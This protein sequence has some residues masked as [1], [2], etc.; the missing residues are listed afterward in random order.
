MNSSNN[1][2]TLFKEKHTERNK[3]VRSP[4]SQGSELFRFNLLMKEQEIAWDLL[5]AS[6]GEDGF[7]WAK[8]GGTADWKHLNH[9]RKPRL[10]IKKCDF[11]LL[12]NGFCMTGKIIYDQSVGKHWEALKL[13]PH[14]GRSYQCSGETSEEG[15]LTP[16]PLTPLCFL[17]LHSA[18]DI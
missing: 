14:R 13:K 1:I 2:N 10:K 7:L 17:Q 18:G 11:C 16:H 9:P 6:Q 4:K 5:R 15:V 8:Q 3:K 12:S